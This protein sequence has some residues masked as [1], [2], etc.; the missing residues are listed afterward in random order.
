MAESDR[1]C[2]VYFVYNHWWEYGKFCKLMIDSSPDICLA[3]M[4][5]YGGNLH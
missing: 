2:T 4:P 5:T 3:A 1:K